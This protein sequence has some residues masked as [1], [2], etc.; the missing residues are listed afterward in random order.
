MERISRGDKPINKLDE[1]CLNHDLDYM[2]AKN[3]EDIVKSDKILINQAWE[4]AKSSETPLKERLD[5][6]LV[7][8][9]MSAKNKLGFGLNFP[10]QSKNSKKLNDIINQLKRETAK[11][12]KKPKKKNVKKEIPLMAAY[13]D[14]KYI[15]NKSVKSKAANKK[16]GSVKKKTQKRKKSEKVQNNKKKFRLL[17]NGLYLK[18]YSNRKN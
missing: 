7:H 12:S 17:A 10:G 1:F 8:Q 3:K 13:I 6:L 15:R 16:G 18:P 11:T 4:R 9:I 2:A 14:E 5:S